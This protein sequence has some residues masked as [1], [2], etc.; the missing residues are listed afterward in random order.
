MQDLIQVNQS[1]QPVVSSRSVADHFGKEHKNVL[2]SIEKLTAE[3]SALTKMFFSATYT[4]GTGK[5][6]P[7]YLM[8]RDGFT[9]LAMGFTGKNALE[10][11]L[12]YIEA[13]NAMEK[14]LRDRQPAHALP[15]DYPS[16]LRAL[17]DAEEQRL[18][19]AAKVEADAPK[20]E[21][22]ERL[23]ARDGL[24]NIRDTAKLLGIPQK[25]FV[26]FL[27][28]NGYCYRDK[29]GRIR[30]YAGKGDG[31]FVVKEY[32]NDATGAHGVQTLVTFEGRELF[33][34]K[35]AA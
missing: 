30:P 20:L 27:I 23:A 33:A 10:W 19:L 2:Q 17:A 5:E 15:Q 7:M 8:N 1:G 28:G 18:A 34:R 6:Y 16:A 12:K 22:Y 21:T 9:I 26:N 13:F 31:L 11:K 35:L 4:A 32:A 3:N 24:T 29:H 14:E 25:R